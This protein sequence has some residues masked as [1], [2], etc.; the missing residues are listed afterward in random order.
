MWSKK[1]IAFSGQPSWI[2]KSCMTDACNREEVNR[3][4]LHLYKWL[5]V[6][7]NGWEDCKFV[8][9]FI[10]TSL[11]KQSWI[12]IST[13][14]ER[15]EDKIKGL[16][17]MIYPK[18]IDTDNLPSP[19]APCWLLSV[20]STVPHQPS[21]KNNKSMTHYFM[22]IQGNSFLSY[23]IPKYAV[24]LL[25]VYMRYTSTL[26]P[27][28][29]RQCLPQNMPCLSLS[30]SVC[31]SLPSLPDTHNC[32]GIYHRQWQYVP[33]G[34]SMCCN[35]GKYIVASNKMCHEHRHILLPMTI[36]AQRQNMPQQHF[37]LALYV[38]TLYSFTFTYVLINNRKITNTH[39]H[40]LTKY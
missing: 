12:N 6:P 10:R 9:D 29:T 18:H 31:L 26:N 37:R 2:N 25:P 28:T 3:K 23:T 22:T 16:F 32:C 35:P 7:D 20:L 4:S 1:L 8:F 14:A 15:F 17:W 30:L 33:M 38:S 13:G 19:P 11:W 24:L 40:T 27:L 36:Y 21:S 5:R 39:T 34:D